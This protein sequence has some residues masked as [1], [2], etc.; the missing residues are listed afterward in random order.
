MLFRSLPMLLGD[1]A[2]G[3]RTVRPAGPVTLTF[4]WPFPLN[5][6]VACLVSHPCWLATSRAAMQIFRIRPLMLAIGFVVVTAS[7]RCGDR[8][9]F[10]DAA[11]DYARFHAR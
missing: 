10:P 7:I 4:G 2:I 1:D 5:E 11:P 8:R 6:I 9:R 3:K